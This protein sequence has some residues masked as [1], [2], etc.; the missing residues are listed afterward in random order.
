MVVK[1]KVKSRKGKKSS[2]GG[3]GKTVSKSELLPPGHRFDSEIADACSNL[4]L[5]AQIERIS[6]PTSI[7]RLLRVNLRK[8]V[9]QRKLSRVS[10]AFFQS[11]L[12]MAKEYPLTAVCKK[13]LEVTYDEYCMVRKHMK[14]FEE[15]SMKVRISAMLDELSDLNWH[16]DTNFNA[17][18]TFPDE[19]FSCLVI[20]AG[21]EQFFNE[22]GRLIQ[23]IAVSV[24]TEE[25]GKFT[26]LAYRHGL[27][28]F[29]ESQKFVCFKL[30]I[31]PDNNI[32][33]IPMSPPSVQAESRND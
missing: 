14:S 24:R 16:T 12:D 25:I 15:Q 32:P 17:G 6:N 3:T 5:K 29:R 21:W 11:I 31:H 23:S 4:L 13:M 10:N 26:E 8:L 33:G 22:E 27:L 7:E 9:S 28:F 18:S 2:Q 20:H 30:K 19:P 1:R